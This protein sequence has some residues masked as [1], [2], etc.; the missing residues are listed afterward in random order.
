MSFPLFSALSMS[1]CAL[2]AGH[3]VASVQANGGMIGLEHEVPPAA[4]ATEV[5][6]RL[7]AAHDFDRDGALDILTTWIQ[8]ASTTEIAVL[9]SRTGAELLRVSIPYAHPIYAAPTLSS[10]ADV[11]GDGVHE[12]AVGEQHHGYS[13]SGAVTLYSGATGVILW[14]VHQS[15]SGDHLGAGLATVGDVDRDGHEDLLAHAPTMRD[16][17]Y[18]YLFGGA[19]LL[20]GLDG[21]E[22]RRVYVADEPHVAH[23]ESR[24][25]RAG[26]VDRDGVPDFLVGGVPGQS[27]SYA[28]QAVVF[29]GASGAVLIH[30]EGVAAAYSYGA[31]VCYAGDVNRDGHP[32]HAVA[33]PALGFVRIISGRDGSLLR[34]HGGANRQ[35]YGIGMSGGRDLDGDAVPDLIVPEWEEKVL[36]IYAGADGT[37]FLTIRA[38]SGTDHPGQQSCVLGD[39]D[40]DGRISFAWSGAASSN[41]PGLPAGSS[42]VRVAEFVRGLAADRPVISATAGGVVRWEVDFPSE[43]AGSPYL[44][45]ASGSGT[46]GGSFEGIHLP[47]DQDAVFARMLAG[48][49]RGFSAAAGNLD[50]AARAAPSLTLAP[51]R[52][53]PWLGSTAWFAV[54]AGP[55]GAR[56]GASVAVPLT[57]TP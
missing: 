51:A 53:W 18:P 9:S 26:D 39:A 25:A 1:G 13:Y 43:L 48:S 22:L 57:I 29:S 46:T 17:A 45:L 52:A 16:P 55:P 20:S 41:L 40:H 56:A 28:G 19:I 32:D 54:V 49:P 11:D 35:D 50:A 42:F 10:V 47:L 3:A 7:V 24:V 12:V 30:S 2:L 33:D 34:T 4:G 5:G 23:G 44:L 14:R 36:H 31:A 27:S 37:E 15:G 8:S 6:R 21:T 38:S